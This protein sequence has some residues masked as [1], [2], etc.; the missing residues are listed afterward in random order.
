[1]KTFLLAASFLGLALTVVPSFFVFYGKIEWELH[2][3]L[4]IAGFILYFGSA[5]FLSKLNKEG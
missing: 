4:M 5:P 2:A 3:N 1:M